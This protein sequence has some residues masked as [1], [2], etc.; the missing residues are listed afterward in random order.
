MFHRYLSLCYGVSA[1]QYMLS[2]T[3][4]FLCCE[5]S[6]LHSNAVQRD[7]WA[8]YPPKHFQWPSRA[9]KDFFLDIYDW[10]TLELLPGSAS[11]LASAIPL[12]T[13][14]FPCY[15]SVQGHKGA[16]LLRSS[17]GT[18]LCQNQLG[19]S[20]VQVSMLKATYVYSSLI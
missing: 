7:L 11:R 4:V 1:D 2:S 20:G 16:N 8:I 5:K 9:E 10:D 12:C 14:R 3:P 17:G 6:L 13:G 19:C 15:L 18:I